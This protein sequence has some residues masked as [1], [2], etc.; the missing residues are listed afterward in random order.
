[1]VLTDGFFSGK[2]EGFFALEALLPRGVALSFVEEQQPEK[3]SMIADPRANELAKRLMTIVRGDG[4]V[5]RGDNGI[6]LPVGVSTQ[7]M[8]YEIS[9]KRQLGWS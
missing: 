6:F 9:T 7:G 4:G 1:M 2:A 3:L 8:L 5:L